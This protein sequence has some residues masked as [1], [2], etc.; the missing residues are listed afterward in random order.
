[1]TIKEL[2]R[3]LDLSITTVSRA[4]NG[5]GDVSEQTRQRVL[6]AAR[7][8]GYQPNPLGQRLRKGRT[9]AVG[10]V[11]PA[12]PGEFADPFF[13]ELAAGLGEGLS[14]HGL[15]LLVTACAPGPE[16]LRCY[17]RL[18]EGRRVDAVVLART[19]RQD[20][21]IL[22]LAERGVPFVAHGRSS[23][24]QHPFPYVDV[25][26]THGFYVAAR[27]LLALG[28]RRIGIINAPQELNFSHHRFEGYRKALIEAGLPQEERL[29]VQGDL[30]E[31]GGYRAMHRL[32]GA[33][34]PP[35]AVLCANDLMAIGAM[36]L[37]RE[38]GLRAGRDISVIGYDDIPMARFT[39]PPLTTLR[40]PIRQAGRRLV[41]MLVSYMSGVAAEK[42]QEVWL[43]ELV[44]R[45][46]AGPPGGRTDSARPDR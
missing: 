18:V 32:L 39:D 23:D 26:G 16:E 25:D 3:A 33:P 21:R 9:E 42:L 2:A 12:P 4:L 41:K 22:Y 24:V 44:L 46:S 1:M 28:H 5:Y 17:R 19:R 36:H 37:L 13:L 6:E 10:L 7:R 34:D 8:L 40:Q 20:E 14:Q 35:T 15:D 38:Q 30:T 45:G 31:E 43:P 29:L 11:I 27:H